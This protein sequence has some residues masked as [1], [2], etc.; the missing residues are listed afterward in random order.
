MHELSPF[1]EVNVNLFEVHS[2]G[3]LG[4]ELGGLQQLLVHA[5][6]HIDNEA[7]ERREDRGG[8]SVW[9]AMLRVEVKLEVLKLARIVVASVDSA[10]RISDCPIMRR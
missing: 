4:R 6:S 1:H 8:G 2:L 10:R 5:H 3:E 7:R 9:V